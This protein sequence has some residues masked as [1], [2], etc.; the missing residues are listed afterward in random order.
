MGGGGISGRHGREK[1]VGVFGGEIWKKERGR[2]IGR[3][4]RR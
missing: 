2:G 3:T 4:G 1:C